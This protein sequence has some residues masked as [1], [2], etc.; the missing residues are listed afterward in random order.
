MRGRVW[1]SKDLI[2]WLIY[3]FWLG[4]AHHVC[5]VPNPFKYVSFKGVYKMYPQ[6]EA[7]WL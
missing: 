7:L 2:Y 4:T 3:P 1:M 6:W 5:A